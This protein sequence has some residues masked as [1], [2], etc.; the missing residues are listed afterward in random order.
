MAIEVFH[1][2][3]GQNQKLFICKEDMPSRLSVKQM[4]VTIFPSQGKENPIIYVT[5]SSNITSGQ[6]E[7]DH[8]TAPYC[9][10]KTPN[11][12]QGDTVVIP[13][14]QNKRRDINSPSDGEF[15]L[16]RNKPTTRVV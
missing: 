5:Y 15:F 11:L 14:P 10:V 7:T 12:V 1:S 16:I 9:L 6:G 3:K 2:A 8:A 4:S 13:I